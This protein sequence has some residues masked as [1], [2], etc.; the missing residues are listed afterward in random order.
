M[1]SDLVICNCFYKKLYIK[2]KLLDQKVMYIN[3]YINKFKLL[4]NFVK[5]KLSFCLIYYY[6][7]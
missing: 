7:L 1:E 3:R 6:K 5:K 2:N 4:S